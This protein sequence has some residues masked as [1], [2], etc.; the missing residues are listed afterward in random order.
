MRLYLDLCAIQ[1]PKD[2]RSNLRVNAEAEAVLAL[3]ALCESGVLTLTASGVHDVEDARNPHP[4][5]R[6]FVAHVLALATYLPSGPDV[7][8]LAHDY[9]QAGMAPLDA[10]HLAAAVQARVEYFCTTDDALL[11][12]GRQA[13]TRSTT[14][15]SPLELVVLLD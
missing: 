13:G 4:D 11:R 5:R 12:R 15:V 7:L 9:R 2:D 3:I 8:R 6:A 14:V 10:L 1:R